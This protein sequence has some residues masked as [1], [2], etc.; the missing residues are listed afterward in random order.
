MDKPKIIIISGSMGHAPLAPEVL[1]K[2]IEKEGIPVNVIEKEEDKKH[3]AEEQLKHDILI[4]SFEEEYQK[5]ENAILKDESNPYYNK[6]R[7]T[8]GNRKKR[9]PK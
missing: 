2:M 9:W 6:F 4:R 8:K 1:S 7:K 3:F 5:T